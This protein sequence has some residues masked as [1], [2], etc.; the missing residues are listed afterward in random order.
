MQNFAKLDPAHYAAEWKWKFIGRQMLDLSMLGNIDQ[1]FE[2]IDG[3][4]QKHQLDSI[5]YGIGLSGNITGRFSYWTQYIMETGKTYASA[6]GAGAGT[7]SLD[8]DAIDLGAKYFF[9]TKVAPTAYFEYVQGS[10]DGDATG[11]ATATA[12]GSTA[13]KDQRFISFGGL[14]LGY[15]LAPQ[16][17]N[18]K[19]MKLGGSVKPFGWSA[20]RI[21]SE[22][23]LQPTWYTYTKDKAAGITSDVAVNSGAGSSK[24]IG[25]EFDFTLAWRLAGDLKYQ[26]KWGRFSPGAAYNNRSSETYWK[27]KLSLD[28]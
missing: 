3:G 1:N 5:F 26:L 4:G 8:A 24:K 13:G 18:I 14:S 7:I 25:S 22:I 17:I 21:W 19:V 9:P 27:L 23:L 15:A 10:G 28:L 6:G 12:G 20:S 11:S 16:L 2:K